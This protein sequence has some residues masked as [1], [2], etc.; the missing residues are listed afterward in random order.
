MNLILAS[1]SRYR[2]QLLQKLGLSFDALPPNTDE[3]PREGESPEALA[4][5]LAIDKAQSV[6]KQH[7]HAIV[8]GSDQVASIEGQKLGKPGTA[9]K[10][11]EQLTRSSGKTVTFNTGLAVYRHVDQKLVSLVD[12]F[13]VRFK[14]LSNAQIRAY[15]E[16]DRPLDCAGSFKSEGLG[17]TL[18][19]S[20]EGRDPNT[21]IGL[22]LIA[23]CD[24]LAEFGLDPLTQA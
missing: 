15:V 18:F 19:E 16:K 10:A 13:V 2:Q 4:L 21:L 11:I 6:A 9:E 17:I 12:P 8:I 5:R 14:P 20:L 3:T 1:T 23:L 7:P 24:A 22:P